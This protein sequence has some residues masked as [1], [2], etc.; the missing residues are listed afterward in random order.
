MVA[1]AGVGLRAVAPQMRCSLVWF[2]GSVARSRRPCWFNR[3]QQRKQRRA[4]A[5]R[6]AYGPPEL[7]FLPAADYRRRRVRICAESLGRA[8]PAFPASSSV[9]SVSSCSKKRTHR[10]RAA[11]RGICVDHRERR[12]KPSTLVGLTGGNRANR[13]A[14]EL[15]AKLTVRRSCDLSPPPITADAV[16]GSALR[17]LGAPV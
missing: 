12:T 8:G 16:C 13:D 17:A 11:R 7:R 9:A 2:T 15:S 5:E 14:P 4:G 3:R 10:K 1:A 6:E